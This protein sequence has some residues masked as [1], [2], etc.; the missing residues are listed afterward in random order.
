MKFSL[1]DFVVEFFHV[2]TLDE[3]SWMTL[4][5]PKNTVLVCSCKKTTQ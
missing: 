3:T 5:T 1:T 2:A 4:I